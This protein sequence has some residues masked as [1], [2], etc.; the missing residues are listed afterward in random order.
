MGCEENRIYGHPQQSS[1]LSRQC[2]RTFRDE[3]GRQASALGQLWL[4]L[5]K[6]KEAETGKRA[7]H[8]DKLGTGQ[9]IQQLRGEHPMYS[10]LTWKALIIS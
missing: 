6:E 8:S 5:S 1:V 4:F 3:A 2:C 9:L 7:R 10:I